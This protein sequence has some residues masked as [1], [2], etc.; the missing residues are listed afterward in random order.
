LVLNLVINKNADISVNQSPG[1][2]NGVTTLN[3]LAQGTRRNANGEID[4]YPKHITAIPYYGWA[5]RG[6]GEMAVWLATEKE[7]SN[8]LPAPTLT[9][10]SSIKAS[11]PTAA[12]RSINDQIYPKSSG[13]ETNP[14]YHTWPRKQQ[15]EWIEYH[16]PESASIS[17]SRVYWFDDEPRGACR[18]PEKWKLLYMTGGRWKEVKATSAYNVVK[19]GWSELSFEPVTTSGIRLEMDFPGNF[20]GGVH[21]WE[22][23]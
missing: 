9:T 8:P 22:V 13:D 4:T 5:H 23:K 15:T 12:L 7:A 14:F 1:L 10:R 6:R 20:S 17:S 16:F 21:E 11:H 2:L 19:D 18:I 3:F